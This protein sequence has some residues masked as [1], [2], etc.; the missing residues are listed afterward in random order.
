MKR[1]F[2]FL[3][4]AVFAACTCLSQ[5]PDQLVYVDQNCEALLPDYTPDV[6]VVDNC[7]NASISQSPSPGT[8]LTSATPVTTVTISALDISGNSASL[9]FE[10]ILLDTISPT[11]QPGPGLLTW[12]AEGIGKAIRR[13]HVG[14]IAMH[15]SILVQYPN[16][17]QDTS[18]RHD[19]LLLINNMNSRLMTMSFVDPTAM[20]M[21]ADSAYLADTCGLSWTSLRIQIADPE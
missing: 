7:D 16:A 10:V 18:Y 5:I 13:M 8:V 20:I 3:I 21:A 14:V 6:V 15:D 4:V 9:S 1:L 2:G 11:I 17:N 19:N 12:N